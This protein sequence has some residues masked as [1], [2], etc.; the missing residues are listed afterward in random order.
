MLAVRV[1][2]PLINRHFPLSWL[3]GRWAFAQS[4]RSVM[5][6]SPPWSLPSPHCCCCCWCRDRGC[7]GRFVIDGKVGGACGLDLSHTRPQLAI[8]GRAWKT[9]F[10]SSGFSH[11]TFKTNLPRQTPTSAR[12]VPNTMAALPTT[13]TTQ[14]AAAAMRRPWFNHNSK[15]SSNDDDDMIDNDGNAAVTRQQGKLK[16]Q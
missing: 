9:L 8:T 2:L 12:P 13:A 15:A 1:A 16:Q 6:A 4:S 10:Q 3:M 7:I 14:Q 11:S 5:V